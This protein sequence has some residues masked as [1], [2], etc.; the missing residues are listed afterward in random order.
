MFGDPIDPFVIPL[1][2]G[3]VILRPHWQ[4]LVECS[5]VC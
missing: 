3:A 4:Y 2:D 1:P 5:G